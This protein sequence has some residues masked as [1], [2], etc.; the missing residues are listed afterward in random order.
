MRAKKEHWIIVCDKC[1]KILDSE[2]VKEIIKDRK[3]GK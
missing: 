3:K 1:H 2:Y